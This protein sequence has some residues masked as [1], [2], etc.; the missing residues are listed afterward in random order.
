MSRMLFGLVLAFFCL[1]NSWAVVPPTEV[2]GI[3]QQ[4]SP[5]GRVVQ[6]QG[7]RYR[8]AENFAVLDRDARE[9]APS[10]VVRGVRVTLIEF[11][12]EVTQ[13]IVGPQSPTTT[14]PGR[15]R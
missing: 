6:V 8:L 12:G 4:W 9:L 15:G 3:V 5:S 1:T 11:D 10:A 2:D 13:I 14:N 7:V